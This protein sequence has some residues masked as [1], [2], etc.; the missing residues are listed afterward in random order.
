MRNYYLPVDLRI[1][2]KDVGVQEVMTL[3]EIGRDSG[4]FYRHWQCDCFKSLSLTP[5]WGRNEALNPQA[6][7]K[8]WPLTGRNH[9]LVSKVK[10]QSVKKLNINLVL[11][12]SNSYEGTM[13]LGGGAHP[14]R[15][16]DK[17]SVCSW[18]WWSACAWISKGIFL[19]AYVNTWTASSCK[20]LTH[21]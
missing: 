16:S 11:V 21:N 5:W 6:P 14:A 1:L 20:V 19:G 3:A 15:P 9:A 8:H 18:H 17:L 7:I 2:K 10:L 12:T 13:V 4:C